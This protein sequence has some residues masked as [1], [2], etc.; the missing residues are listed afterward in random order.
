LFLN[1]YAFFSL[2]FQTKP[3]K[4]KLEEE[5]E[6]PRKRQRQQEE[7]EVKLTRFVSSFF[8]LPA[9]LS[10]VCLFSPLLPFRIN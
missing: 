6:M 10:A 7:K 4:R 3:S 8:L 2:A 9:R 1:W 5:Q